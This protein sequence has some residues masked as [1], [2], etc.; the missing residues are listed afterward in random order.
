MLLGDREG[1]DSVNADAKTDEVRVAY[2]P[3]RIGLHEIEEA[4]TFAWIVRSPRPRSGRK[5]RLRRPTPRGFQP[6]A[7]H[8]SEL[9]QLRDLPYLSQ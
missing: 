9:Q 4:V 1:V 2:G 5:A 8:P 6:W 7:A 3:E